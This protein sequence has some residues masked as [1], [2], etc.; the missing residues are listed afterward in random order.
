[1][2]SVM[3]LMCDTRPVNKLSVSGKGEKVARFA[4]SSL[5]STED[6]QFRR[7]ASSLSPHQK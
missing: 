4:K 7:Q 2:L 3:C 5:F 1:M 6:G